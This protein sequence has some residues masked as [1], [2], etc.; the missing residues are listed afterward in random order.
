MDKSVKRQYAIDGTLHEKEKWY[1]FT[2]PD[3]RVYQREKNLP[4]SEPNFHEWWKRLEHGLPSLKEIYRCDYYLSGKGRYRKNYIP[5]AE[6]ARLKEELCLKL[7]NHG[8]RYTASYD[9]L[10]A[11]FCEKYPEKIA[12]EDIRDYGELCYRAQYRR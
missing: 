4:S 2:G 7:S 12:K 6:A 1:L 5:P 8:T 11:Y 9:D 3:G 10:W